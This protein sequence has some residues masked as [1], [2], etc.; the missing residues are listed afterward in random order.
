VDAWGHQVLLNYRSHRSPQNIA[1]QVT[2][3]NVLNGQIDPNSIKDRIVLIGTTANSFRDYWLTPYSNSQRFDQQ[4][5]GVLVQ[6]HMVS[7]ILSAVLDGRSLLWVWPKWGEVLWIWG[8]SLIGGILAWRLRSPLHFWI[9][10]V[11]GQISL[12]G[13]CFGLLVQTGCWVPL[14]PS[15]LTLLATSGSVAAYTTVQARRQQ[16]KSKFA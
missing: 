1:A 13:F 9:A 14:V 5:P 15:A 10:I 6:A 8:W 2:L 4:M 16:I 11:A 7:Q 12:Y 3:A